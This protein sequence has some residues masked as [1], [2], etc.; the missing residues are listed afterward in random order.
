MTSSGLSDL[1]RLAFG[2]INKM[3]SS[4]N[5]PPDLMALRMV[6]EELLLGSIDDMIKFDDLTAF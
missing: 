2:S 4:K 6:V 1:L 3:L 5:F